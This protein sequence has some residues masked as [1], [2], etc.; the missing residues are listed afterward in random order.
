MTRQEARER[1]ARLMKPG[2]SIPHGLPTTRLNCS[3]AFI[4]MW[5]SDHLVKLREERTGDR[6]EVGTVALTQRLVCPSS[7]RPQ[8]GLPL[9]IFP[10]CRAQTQSGSISAAD[11]PLADA[12]ILPSWPNPSTR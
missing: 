12:A 7:T 1:S 2:G 5:K 4:I 3:H 11:P 8:S 10:L 6:G 9:I